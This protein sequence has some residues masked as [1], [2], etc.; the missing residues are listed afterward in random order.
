MKFSYDFT[1]N[2]LVAYYRYHNNN[3]PTARKRNFRSTVFGFIACLLFAII[4]T[5]KDGRQFMIAARVY[6]VFYLTPI[7]F[8]IIF[9]PFSKFQTRRYYNKYLKEGDSSV[10][11]DK[12]SLSLEDD[13]I[14][15]ANPESQSILFW[16]SFKKF[17]MTP[18]YLFLYTSGI[19]ALV[20][21]RRAFESEKDLED[22]I[23]LFSEKT[24]VSVTTV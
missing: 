13:G 22:F 12:W 21:P 4:I 20:I 9:I 6:W 17:I 5:M 10:F 11:F 1:R 3:S 18:D 8:L 14:H 19:T 15:V 23:Q 2:D 7:L 24:D 16:P